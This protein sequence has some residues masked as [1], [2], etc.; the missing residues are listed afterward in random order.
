M[1]SEGLGRARRCGRWLWR[2]RSATRRANRGE[3]PA[4]PIRR[5]RP[6]AARRR[7]A[8][9]RRCAAWVAGT[10]RRCLRQ[11]GREGR[12]SWP[13]VR[14][15]G[16]G[17]FHPVPRSTHLEP[18]RRGENGPPREARVWL[19][20]VKRRA[21]TRMSVVSCSS[22]GAVRSTRSTREV[23]GPP[24]ARARSKVAMVVSLRSLTK[25]KPRVRVWDVGSAT[26]KAPTVLTHGASMRA[27][28]I[29]A[30]CT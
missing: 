26:A 13:R 3:S 23:K 11:C 12:G 20:P 25:L 10:A 19:A 2:L 24:S 21:P 1:R 14:P 15:H 18:R 9:G 7:A 16:R 29:R 28:S 22:D 6:S 4:T 5:R 27:P 8:A 17:W 30:S